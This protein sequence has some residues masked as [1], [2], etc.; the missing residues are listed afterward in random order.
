MDKTRPGICPAMHPD[1]TDSLIGHRSV[2]LVGPT[3]SP[4]PVISNSEMRLN[5]VRTEE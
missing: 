1:R 2:V 3:R 4:D 5:A